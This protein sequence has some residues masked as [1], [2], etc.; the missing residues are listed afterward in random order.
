MELFGI[1]LSIPAAF[2]ASVMYSLFLVLV[3]RR[4]ERI[5]RWLWWVS[6][7]VLGFFVLEL[8]LLATLGA[9]A[10]R[11]TLGPEFY[12][13]HLALFFF[14]TPA[15]ANLLLLRQRKALILW[16]CVAVFCC[17]VFAFGSVLLQYG[18]SEALYG[19]D[20]D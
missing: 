20:G 12:A 4:F 1:I 18:V 11:A 15:L 19:V 5:S 8:F 9:V 6:V 2:V 17:T 13:V 10:S 7:G 3:V 16:T 14:G